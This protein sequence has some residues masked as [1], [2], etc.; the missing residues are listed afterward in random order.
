MFPVTRPVRQT[1]S[2]ILLL[3]LTVF[4][5]AI[6]A[7][8]AWRINQP[9]HVRDVEIELGRNLGMQVSLAS[10]GYPGP[11]EIIYRGLVLRGQEPRGKGFAEIARADAVRLSR[12]DHELTVLLENPELHAESPALG[13]A[14]LDHFIQRS[15][16]LPF[17]RVALGAPTCRIELG[18]DD[19]HFT[20]KDVAGEFLSDA[21][22]PALKLAYD[23]PDIGKGSRCELI[24][25]RDRRSEPFETS[26]SLKTVE[27][28]P[29]PARMLNVFFDAEDWLG[30]EA[31]VLGK[32]NLRQAGSTE[33]KADFQGEVLDLDLA[34]LIGRRFPRHR[35]TGRA[36]I[37]FEKAIWGQRPGGQGPGWLEVKGELVAGQGAIGVALLE[38]LAREMRFRPSAR[39]PQVD[40]RKTDVDFRSLGLSFAI[41][42]NGEIQI[43]GALGTEFPPDAVI[44]GA[45]SALLSAPQGTAS[46]HGLIKTLFPVSPNNSGVLIPLTTESQALFSLPLPVGAESPVRRTLDGN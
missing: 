13:L 34:R 27:G 20:F 31:K 45:S 38:A 25:T 35:L 28:S 14:I 7:A 6:V 12:A 16:S 10:V 40:S 8:I 26:L 46:V 22:A 23:I 39:K 15:I 36:R 32:L 9:G 29:L 21:T 17:Q 5:T 30:T 19:L 44:A 37:A 33:W 43:S 4:P 1:I 18:R 11:G 42:S 41:H 24:L 2:T 3:G